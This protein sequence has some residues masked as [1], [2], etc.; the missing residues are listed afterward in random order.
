MATSTATAYASTTLV[1]VPRGP[2]F[3]KNCPT[4]GQAPESQSHPA[5]LT[6]RRVKDLEGHV[7]F[8]N[9]QAAQMS[10]KLL[11][12]EA[13]MRRLRVQANQPAPGTSSFTPRNGLSIS[14]TSTSSHSPS[15]SNSTSQAPP[16]QVVPPTQSR[17]SSLASLLPYRRPSTASSQPQ[18][19]PPPSPALQQCQPMPFTQSPPPL[20]PRTPTPRPSSEETLELQNALSRE[21]SLR[22]AAE[23]QLTQASSELEELTAQLFSQANEMVAQER[24]A[25]ARLEERVAVLERRDVEKRNR[26]ERLEK[27]MERVERIRALVG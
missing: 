24:K 23:T 17:L 3:E 15:N 27:A 13:E 11:E 26:L 20:E 5:E 7:Q 12:Y 19:Q 6:R 4:C 10:E 25:R 8:L 2:A 14:S 21:Q 18:S 9:E 16:Q 1:S 22:K